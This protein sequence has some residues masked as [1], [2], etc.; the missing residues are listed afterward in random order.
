VLLDDPH[1]LLTGEGRTVRYVRVLAP[2]DPPAEQL[3]E[4]IDAAVL[5]GTPGRQRPAAG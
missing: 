1:G 4:L 5:A 2:G 3:V